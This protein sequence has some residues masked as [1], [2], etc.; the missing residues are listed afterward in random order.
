MALN[1]PWTLQFHDLMSTSSYKYVVDKNTLSLEFFGGRVKMAP[2]YIY[3]LWAMYLL[4]PDT[5]LQKIEKHIGSL[6][7]GEFVDVHHNLVDYSVS[8]PMVVSRVRFFAIRYNDE[9]T[10]LREAV[11]SRLLEE[12]YYEAPCD[13]SLD[14]DDKDT[15]VYQ[16]Y[17]MAFKPKK[18][19]K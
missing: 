5:M 3:D 14:S 15:I 16:E 12:M 18:K 8:D 11:R 6:E 17:L 2:E 19:K 1:N 13:M 10:K 7:P 9:A 4:H